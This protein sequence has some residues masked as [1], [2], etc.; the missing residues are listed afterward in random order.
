M[1]AGPGWILAS[2]VELGGR[3]GA[4]VL[5][6]DGTRTL[7]DTGGWWPFGVSADGSGRFW[8]LDE[9]PDALRMVEMSISGVPT[10]SEIDLTSYP[11]LVDPR[12]GIVVDAPGGSY[13]VTPEG[14][15]RLS[16]GTVVA[17]GRHWL[18][19]EECDGNL[20]CGH[21]M[22]DR[23]TGARRRIE[24]ESGLGGLRLRWNQTA[25]FNEAEDALLV[26]YWDP[27]DGGGLSVGVVDLETGD[28][29]ELPDLNPYENGGQNVLWGPGD[30]LFWLDALRYLN[31]FD[32]ETGESV[33]FSDELGQLNGFALRQFAP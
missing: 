3:S 23:A 32:P 17:A 27:V 11:R 2:P 26:T 16:P 9:R 5:T 15:T 7:I 13:L 4:V 31:V 10:G 25:T 14:A 22:V 30:R 6:D 28:F 12:G 20:E 8:L 1:A 33:L 21:F 24:L 19:V 18:L 29:D